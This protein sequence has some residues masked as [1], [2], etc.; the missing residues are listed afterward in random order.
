MCA[1]T[2]S[3]YL[4]ML[5]CRNKMNFY[6]F[7]I[8]MHHYFPC[9]MPERWTEFI[10][11]WIESDVE[12]RVVVGG[13]VCVRG[14]RNVPIPIYTFCCYLIRSVWFGRAISVLGR[15]STQK[16]TCTYNGAKRQA[17]RRTTPADKSFQCTFAMYGRR[18]RNGIA[19]SLRVGRKS[20]NKAKSCAAIEY[21]FLFCLPVVCG[22]R[23]HSSG[24]DKLR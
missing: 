5:R 6:V 24:V 12:C 17:K 3:I 19:E 11:G 13:R 4:M 8:L 9:A 10:C 23:V 14:C 22:A 16:C 18:E 7:I 21:F 15:R 20:L 2:F 1:C